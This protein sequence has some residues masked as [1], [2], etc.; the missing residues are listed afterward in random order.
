[1]T[2]DKLTLVGEDLRQFDMK[3][4]FENQVLQDDKKCH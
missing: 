3:D 1:M 4:I 2:K